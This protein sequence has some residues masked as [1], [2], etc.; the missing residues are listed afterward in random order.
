[1]HR[2]GWNKD[3]R[4]QTPPTDFNLISLN[5]QI[6]H[7][8][9]FKLPRKP[10]NVSKISVNK[11]TNLCSMSVSNVQFNGS[12]MSTE[13]GYDFHWCTGSILTNVLPAVT[14]DSCGYQRE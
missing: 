3:F 5:N 1:M 11:L 2:R 7:S 13:L 4:L 12:D 10:L 9:E 8:L 14:S 6:F